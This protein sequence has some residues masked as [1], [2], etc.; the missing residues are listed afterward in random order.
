[1]TTEYSCDETARP[2]LGLPSAAQLRRRCRAHSRSQLYDESGTEPLGLAIYTLSD[3][4]DIR[5]VR[6]VGQTSSPRRRFLQ[7]LN[8]AQLWL[9][10]EL[11]WWVKEPK[12]RPLYTWVRELYRDDYRL[13]VMVVTAWAATVAE[14]RVLER[15]RIFGCLAD[16]RKLLNVEM[17]ILQG[18]V[19]L[20]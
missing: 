2:P 6:Y 15:A 5:D 14:A 9:P 4:R 8:Q 10:D 12:L 1:V 18:R 3:P 11:P 20:L 17:E 16:Q 7:H 13:P 19:P